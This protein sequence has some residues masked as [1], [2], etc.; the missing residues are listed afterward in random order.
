VGLALTP[1]VSAGLALALALPLGALSV[2]SPGL[3]LACVAALAFLALTLRDVAAGLAAFI[4]LA[5]VGSIS[6]LAGSPAVKLAGVVLVVALLAKRLALLRLVHEHPLV[7]L[8]A[9]FVVAWAFSSALWATDAYAAESTSFRLALGLVFVFVVFAAVRDRRQLR[10]VVGALIVGALLASLVGA[11][12]L[13]AGPSSG[14]LGGG[15]GDPNE[16]ASVLVPA[17]ALAT[18]ALVSVRV[19]WLRIALAASIVALAASLLLTGSRGGLLAVAASVVVAIVCGGA[20]RKRVALVAAAVIALGVGYYTY[21]ASPAAV[22]R[23]SSFTAQGGAGRLD[24]WAVAG[25][26]AADRPIFGAGAGNF[27]A[28][29]A[30]YVTETRNLPNAQFVVDKL[31]VHNTYLELVAELG[32]LGLLAFAFIVLAA[33]VATVRA[34][35]IASAENDRELEYLARGTLVAIVGVLVAV[36]FF[37]GEYEKHLWFILGLGFAVLTVT[38]SARS[39]RLSAQPTPARMRAVPAAVG[40]RLVAQP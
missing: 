29:E 25:S 1:R 9:I 27:P 17:L 7:A 18:F 36:F 4:V 24:M 11:L 34:I 6:L 8:A 15:V 13:S 19:L 39:V 12:Q 35:R 33:I 37:S 30:V 38:R 22:Q 28:V 14:R 21:I 5:C 20:I 10:W 2:G 16:L 23:V 3:A 32:P 26:V 40:P 31:V